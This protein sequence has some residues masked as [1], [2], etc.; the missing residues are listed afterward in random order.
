MHKWSLIGALLWAST[1]CSQ[2]ALNNTGNLQL[3]AGA[4]V[5]IHT[6]ANNN[7][8]IQ[9]DNFSLLGAYGN[10]LYS[11][12][13]SNPF[14]TFDFE[15]ANDAGLVLQTPLI[16]RNNLNFISGQLFTPHTDPTITASFLVDAFFNGES[17]SSFVDGFAEIKD[18]A[19]FSF[20]VGD[21]EQL[22]PLLINS[23]G[24]NSTASCAYLLENPTAPISVD[25]SLDTN[26]TVN[27][28]GDV[29]TTEF[30]IL[31]GAISSTVTVSW[32]TRSQLAAMATEVE[33][34]VLVGWSKAA[35]RW[36]IIGNSATSGNLNEGFLV[37]N[38]F[39]P[40]DFEAITFG[41]TP[42][43]TDTFATNYPTL[44]NYF[45]SPNGDGINDVL[46]F[47][48]WDQI[49][50]SNVLHIY[51]RF[52]QKVYTKENYLNNEFNGFSNI[53]NFVIKREEGLPDDIYYYTVS[54][55]DMDLNYQG[56]FYLKR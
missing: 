21:Q 37:S 31:K 19:D 16:I 40:N 52:G 7:G 10:Q 33:D 25:F 26:N 50:G 54:L 1:G 53:D 2:T 18:K 35:G 23:N 55:P 45:V 3:H 44:G 46:S 9:A 29:S 17:N 49:E 5:G 13:G 8:T 24:V 12:T 34:I 14:N 48:D 41:T 47:D 11:F 43:P 15:L 6:N 32:N 22:R 39:I 56:F 28:I 4:A 27:D 20:P 38:S 36:T 51:N 42:I 30:W